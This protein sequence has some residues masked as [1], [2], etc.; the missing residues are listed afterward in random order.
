MK[1][2]Y[3]IPISISKNIHIIPKNLMKN[4]S[5]EFKKSHNF[6]D[7]N[8]NIYDFDERKRRAKS[9]KNTFSCFNN[10]DNN[11]DELEI[12][13]GNISLRNKSSISTILS[14]K[15]TE[16][17]DIIKGFN[18][19]KK[20]KMINKK[21]KKKKNMS[22]KNIF[23]NLKNL[24][25]YKSNLNRY[26]TKS[27]LNKKNSKN[28]STNNSKKSNISSKNNKSSITKMKNSKL[29]AFNNESNQKLKINVSCINNN[30]FSKYDDKMLN[31]INIINSTKEN[32]ISTNKNT[33]SENRDLKNITFGQT[34][35]YK[36]PSEFVYIKKNNLCYSNSYNIKSK[37][38]SHINSTSFSTTLDKKENAQIQKAINNINISEFRLE[39]DKESSK[40]NSITD[41]NDE[42]DDIEEDNINQIRVSYFGKYKTIKQIEKKIENDI[43]INRIIN[44]NIKKKINIK[45]EIKTTFKK[46]NLNMKIIIN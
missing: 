36:I 34:K 25:D 27:I 3:S 16:K 23:D 41:I 13:D 46:D 24:N 31:T 6:I 2:R 4:G 8:I 43:I 17:D 15:Q 28:N 40:D 9:N 38:K 14:L 26:S 33:D 44:N 12:I 30:S 32:N 11:Y 37:N 21:P 42:N 19:F 18:N 35:P 7:Q 20:K 5:F 22:T 45:K 10:V 1:S 39:E 29:N